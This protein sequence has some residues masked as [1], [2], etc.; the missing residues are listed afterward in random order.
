M[1]NCIINKTSYIYKSTPKSKNL[2]FPFQNTYQDEYIKNTSQVKNTYLSKTPLAF[3]S[4]KGNSASMKKLTTV[5]LKNYNSSNFQCISKHAMIKDLTSKIK[6]YNNF[7]PNQQQ[8]H[9]K[10]VL[11]I[12]VIKYKERKT[13]LNISK[14]DNGLTIANRINNELELNFNER[15]IHFLS[16]KIAKEI[17]NIINVITFNNNNTRDYGVVID[18]NEI[19]RSSSEKIKI[20]VRLGK[21]YLYYYIHN[22]H[23]EDEIDDIVDNIM[24]HL[25]KQGHYDHDR[26]RDTVKASVK[27]SIDIAKRSNEDSNK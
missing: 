13:E 17:N 15:E 21:K 23:S 1:I 14:D 2:E 7:S 18:I 3:P 25:S 5:N 9:N 4:K 19:L 6:K 24:A 10:N 16:V 26:L 12:I 22:Y 8:C 20:V 11:M 27:E